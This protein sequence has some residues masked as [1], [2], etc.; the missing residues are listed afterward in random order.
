LIAVQLDYRQMGVGG[1]N[2]WGARPLDPH[3]IPVQTH[4]W[5]VRLTPLAPGSE[6]LMELTREEFPTPAAGPRPKETR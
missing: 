5:A 1:D 4:S 3:Q 6:N 2:S